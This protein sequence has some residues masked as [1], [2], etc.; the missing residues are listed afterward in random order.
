[1]NEGQVDQETVAI[2]QAAKD[3][4]RNEGL[5][6]GRRYVTTDAPQLTQ[7]GRKKKQTGLE[8]SV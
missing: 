1:M 4:C 5:K 6:N 2:I 8:R 3:K 7:S